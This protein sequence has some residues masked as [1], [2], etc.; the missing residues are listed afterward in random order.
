MQSTLVYPLLERIAEMISD[1][2]QS[3]AK[4]RFAARDAERYNQMSDAELAMHNLTREDIP[5]LIRR[6]YF[7]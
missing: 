3:F 4:A 2:A 6:R 7:D 1:V 5:A